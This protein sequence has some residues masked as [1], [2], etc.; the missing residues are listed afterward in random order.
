MIP[1]NNRLLIDWDLDTYQVIPLSQ[2]TKKIRWKRL[3]HEFAR[4]IK[5]ASDSDCAVLDIGGGNGLF[6]DFIKNICSSYIVLDPSV[7]QINGFR[8]RQGNNICQGC[9]ESLPFKRMKFDIIILKAVLDH[10]IQPAR[11]LAE[12]FK[13]LKPGGKIFILLANEGAWYKKIFKKYL[14]KRRLKCR[15]HN[16]FFNPQEISEMLKDN[17]FR[18]ITFRHF[19]F[20]RVPNILENLMYRCFPERILILFLNL[21]DKIMRR[22]VPCSGGVFICKA[23]RKD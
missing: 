6:Y 23:T 2:L 21:T 8:L 9:G 20:F 14:L 13:V 12:S 16:Y 19:D 17:S 11:V 3:I 22:M 18:D 5:E 15:S 7:A 1:E 10:C 4:L